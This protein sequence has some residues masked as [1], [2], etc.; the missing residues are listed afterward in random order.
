MT[1]VTIV[2]AGPAGLSAAI[3]ASA[4]GL[5]ATVIEAGKIGGQASASSRIENYAGYPNGISG[6]S[7]T[8]DMRR[9]ACRLGARFVRGRAISLDK[10]TVQLEDGREL[11]SDNVILAPGLTFRAPTWIPARR[12]KGL[13]VA[14]T[15]HAGA[16]HGKHVVI[17]G[18]ANS[19][20]Q[21]AI[22]AS[23]FARSVT[24]LARH[25]L[26]TS[27]YLTERIGRSFINV[28]E[29]CEVTGLD[30]ARGRLVGCDTTA[31]YLPVDAMLVFTGSQPE[32]GWLHTCGIDC[33]PH[34]YVVCDQSGQ[35]SRPRVYAAGD[36]VSGAP[37]RVATAVGSGAAVV[38]SILASG[39][40]A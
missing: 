35:T 4:E 24:I 17:V 39:R 31:G 25:Q 21:A 26:E 29:A 3:N 34:G 16:L 1:S 20:G 15:P 14:Y 9:Q 18:A 37:H 13:H 27:A 12:A 10:T 28:R 5:E 6:W 22:Y 23:S 36:I 7:L 33:D 38:A 2:G 32:T 19:A 40:A 30:T 8:N 11:A